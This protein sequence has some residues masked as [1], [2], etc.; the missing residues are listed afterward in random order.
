VASRALAKL[1]PAA[2]ASDDLGNTVGCTAALLDKTRLLQTWQV[3]QFSQWA[4]GVV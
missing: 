2:G 3:P 4:L 1:K